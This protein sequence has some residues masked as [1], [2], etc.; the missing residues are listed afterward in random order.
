MLTALLVIAIIAAV[1]ISCRPLNE[2]AGAQDT[3]R[4]HSSQRRPAA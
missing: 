2:D 3:P 4:H 1:V